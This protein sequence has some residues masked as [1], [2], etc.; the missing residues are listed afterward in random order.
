MRF[1]LV[2][3]LGR[4]SSSPPPP[5][6]V[7]PPLCG[8]APSP[9]RVSSPPA[10]AGAARAPAASSSR[11]HAV[12]AAGG[13]GGRV[14]RELVHVPADGVLIHIFVKSCLTQ[15]LC[16]LNGVKPKP[17]FLV[18]WSSP[19]DVHAPPIRTQQWF[20]VSGK[21]IWHHS[22]TLSLVPSQLDCTA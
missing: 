6:Y 9:R 14:N 5:S 1:C 18:L 4:P 17:A 15:K 19:G 10:H 21:Q 13:H 12:V 2:P 8:V 7:L 3:A 16:V 22:S 11:A 20:V